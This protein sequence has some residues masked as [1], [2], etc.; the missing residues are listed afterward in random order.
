MLQGPVGGDRVEARS[1]RQGREEQGHEGHDDDEDHEQ[2]GH[3]AQT[4]ALEAA[5]APGRP[6]TSEP[7]TDRAEV[8]ERA[9]EGTRTLGPAT[10]QE[11]IREADDERRAHGQHDG[12]ADG[13]HER[14]GIGREGQVAVDARRH[15]REPGRHTEHGRHAEGGHAQDEGDGGRTGEDGP[16]QGQRHAAEGRQASAPDARAA[17]SR[18]GSARVARPATTTR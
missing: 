10:L 17:R 14:V 11:D 5:S 8:T 9:T 12:Q 7:G 4:P 18:S 15:G 16:Q 3:D 1:T 2:P 13:A 6:R